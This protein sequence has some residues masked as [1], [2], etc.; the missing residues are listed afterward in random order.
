MSPEILREL[1]LAPLWV[2]RRTGVPSE[3]VVDSEVPATA[4][5]TRREA[6]L[7]MDWDAL[8][9]AIRECT[10]CPLHRTRTQGVVGVGDRKAEWLLVGEAP[11]ADEDAQGEPFVGRAGKLLDNML[12]AIA[13]KR[14][15]KV[16][17]AN[18]L[19]SRPPKNRDPEPAEIEACLPYLE[20]Q[21]ALIAPR[22]I[23]A[24]GRFAAQTLLGTDTA[25]GRLRGRV[26]DYQG[27][28]LIVTYHPAYLLR[29]PADKAKVWE[30]L[31][32]A[33]DTMDT[34]KAPEPTQI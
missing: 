16:Y 12:A 31:C 15:D 20:R 24:L 5:P 27:V 19:K 9:D 11:G 14:G 8:T 25:L 2:R 13:L 10:A 1:E 23:L 32:F 21:I 22:L 34:L 7:R 6:I 3:T 18:V 30:D 26:H 29:T 4:A 28:P 17:I 33:L